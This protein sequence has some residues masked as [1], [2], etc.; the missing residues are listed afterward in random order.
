M[1]L[2]PD[3]GTYLVSKGETKPFKLTVFNDVMLGIDGVLGWMI[4][5]ST[6]KFIALGTESRS[7][8]FIKEPMMFSIYLGRSSKSRA[9]K[10]V[11]QLRTEGL[12]V[13]TRES[14]KYLV[15]N[16]T[17]WVVPLEYLKNEKLKN[18]KLKKG[19]GR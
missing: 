19:F 1:T 14:Q 9:H 4:N 6:R 16:G 5:G 7:A 12:L 2:L 3:L 11:K 15:P 10:I 13:V 17:E 8:P 18:A